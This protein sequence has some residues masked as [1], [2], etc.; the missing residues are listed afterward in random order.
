ML[1]IAC[2]REVQ[3]MEEPKVVLQEP[4]ASVPTNSSREIQ[5][6]QELNTSVPTN[7][8]YKYLSSFW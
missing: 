4:N 3:E 6:L 8:F 7:A 1:S 2:N 5:E